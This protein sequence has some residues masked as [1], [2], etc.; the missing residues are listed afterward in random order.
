M[1]P[2][3]FPHQWFDSYY[4]LQFSLTESTGDLGEVAENNW[5][6]GSIVQMIICCIRDKLSDEKQEENR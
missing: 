6:L 5:L 2:V 3:Y 1:A 4:F